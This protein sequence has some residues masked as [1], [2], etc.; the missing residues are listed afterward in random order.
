MTLSNLFSFT[1]LGASLR[2][3]P[4][5]MVIL[6]MI[7]LL[8]S[9]GNGSTGS[10]ET[11]AGNG[12]SAA[13]DSGDNTDADNNT[14]TITPA[15]VVIV[16]EFSFD[17]DEYTVPVGGVVDVTIMLAGEAPADAFSIVLQE[18][19]NDVAQPN[20][21]INFAKGETAHVYSY[22]VSGLAVDTII[23]LGFKDLPEGYQR[24]SS[25]PA[26][27]TVSPNQIQFSAAVYSVEAG[28][29]IDVKLKIGTPLATDV[30][31]AIRQYDVDID[32]TSFETVKIPAGQTEG[33]LKYLAASSHAEG[34]VIQYTIDSVPAELQLGKNAA[35]QVRIVSDPNM[36]DIVVNFAKE[37][38]SVLSGTQDEIEVKITSKIKL[39]GSV[40]IPYEYKDNGANTWTTSPVTFEPALGETDTPDSTTFV[41]NAT[42]VPSGGGRS[43][44]ITENGLSVLR[45][46]GK[47]VSLGRPATANVTVTGRMLGFRDATLDVDYQAN[48]DIVVQLTDEANAFTT[49]PLVIKSVQADGSAVTENAFVSFE[50]GQQEKTHVYS[51]IWQKAWQ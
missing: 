47:K 40:T 31:V 15:D 14:A 22:H 38:Y 26:T 37:K 8:Y 33:S 10:D 1:Y 25:K 9:C 29:E 43:Y 18:S 17:A 46:Q 11:D 3:L 23:K 35:A 49:I 50:K 27:I 51:T 32:E 16:G 42:S 4:R 44:R 19:I 20:T 5:L 12:G 41:Y 24:L 6:T 48:A 39:T 28:K 2:K 34:R 36:P 21:L 13:N 45:V 30:D 7:G